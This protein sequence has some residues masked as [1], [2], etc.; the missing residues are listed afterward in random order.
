MAKGKASILVV[1]DE[2]AMRLL[3]TS[4]LRDEGHDVTSAAS[5]EEA[6]QLVAKRHYHL[7]ITDLKMPGISGLEVLETV[8]RDDPETAVI[9]LTAFGT[10]EGAVEAMRKGA[11]HYLL[12]PLANPD[13][14]RLAVRRVLE[15]RRVA[16]EAATL[17][18][19]TEAVFPFGEIIAGDPKMQAALDLARSVAPADSTVLLTGETGTGKELVARL[20]HHLSPRA[21]QAFV[22]VNCAAL[23]ETLLESE[24]FGHE[25]GA[26]TGAVAQR[27]GR[28]ELAH[29]G[30]LL[31]DEVGEMSPA[32]QAKL[33]R[34][35]QER[36]LE[37]VGGT[38]TVTVDV[39]VIA[40]ANR[41]LQQMVAGKQ[42]RDDLFYRLSVFPIPL[43][44]LRE[45][46][47]DIL[48]L[49][50]HILGQVTRRL[51]KRIVGFSPDAAA[52]LTQYRWPGNIRELQNVVERAVILC[53]GE[54]VL[55][56]HL[57]LMHP[58]PPA[59]GPK[60]LKELEREAIL[61]ALAACQGNRRTAAEQL[62]IGLRT[63]YSR[64]KDFGI[65]TE[66]EEDE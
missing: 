21:D 14:L 31:L 39:R 58:A 48:P 60:T 24:L 64:L 18:Q 28:F 51:G 5:G 35:L 54:H 53:Q 29:G 17:R 26:F 32:L 63:L 9:L 33:L 16:D 1:D 57:N 15:E 11:A 8:R 6:L 50:E 4:V 7:I 23:A 42:F 25:K 49:A 56:A 41:D 38:K 65:S 30:T 34:V 20:I 12:K 22:A 2:A 37:R 27:R 55:L 3:V 62:G 61:A 46:P 47:S 19:A 52:T 59:G 45:R 66:H 44:P 36:T 13:E 43:P 10:V 40:A